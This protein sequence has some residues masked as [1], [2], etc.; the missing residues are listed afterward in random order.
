MNNGEINAK[1]Y[2]IVGGGDKRAGSQRR[3]NPCFLQYKRN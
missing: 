1:A 3:V 2:Q